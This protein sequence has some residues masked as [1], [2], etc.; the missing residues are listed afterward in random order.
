FGFPKRQLPAMLAFVAHVGAGESDPTRRP[1]WLRVLR[2]L[3]R[4]L[5]DL[6][7]LFDPAIRFLAV[8]EEPEWAE[9]I[10]RPSLAP[11]LSRILAARPDRGRS[12]YL[13][14]ARVLRDL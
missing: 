13:L 4:F 5:P 14:V 6:A 12:D 7:D 3:E 10:T 2:R 9:P 8:A 1:V 11:E